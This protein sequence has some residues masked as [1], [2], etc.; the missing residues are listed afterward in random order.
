M[1][2]RAWPKDQPLK[3]MSSKKKPA[4]REGRENGPNGEMRFG[5]AKSFF[6]GQMIRKGEEEWMPKF[7]ADF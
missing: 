1:S 2:T 5:H 6:G 3:K 7:G 4:I